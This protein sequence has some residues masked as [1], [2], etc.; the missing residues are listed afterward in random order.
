[1]PPNATKA[2]RSEWRSS[3]GCCREKG[4]GV[5]IDAF[6]RLDRDDLTLRI[7]GS[8]GF[9]AGAALSDFELEIR[10]AAEPLGDRVEFTPF[11]P[12]DQVARI[13]GESDI[14]VVASTWR[15]PLGLTALEGMAAGAAVIASDVGGIPEAVRGAGILVPPGDAG[16]LATALD[17][18]AGDPELLRRTADACR[19]RAEELDWSH[20]ASALASAVRAVG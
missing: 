2:E 1:M 16:A 14:V 17:E 6:R 19:A 8:Q 20:A 5:V 3:A 7:V 4:A 11:V 15:E 10:R 9:D 13:L 18:L 12:R